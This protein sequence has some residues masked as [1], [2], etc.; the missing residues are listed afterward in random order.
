M[1][2]LKY[3]LTIIQSSLKMFYLQRELESWIWKKHSSTSSTSYTNRKRKL[4]LM[5]NNPRYGRTKRQI[6]AFKKKSNWHRDYSK[7]FLNDLASNSKSVFFYLVIL[8]KNVVSINVYWFDWIVNVV[9]NVPQNR[10][11]NILS[12]INN[13]VSNIIPSIPI[14]ILPKNF[15]RYH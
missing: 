2:L 5:R 10:D 6:S 9:T 7:D 1:I 15:P 11:V 12:K 3:L 8:V 4:K 14:K 13:L